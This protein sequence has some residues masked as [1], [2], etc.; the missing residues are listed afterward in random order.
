MATRPCRRSIPRACWPAPPSTARSKAATRRRRNLPGPRASRPAHGHAHL[1]R[2]S[3]SGP[4]GPRSRKTLAPDLARNLDTARELGPLL[5][6]GQQVAF[7]GAGEAALR[8]QA[9]LLQ[10]RELRGLVDA[11]LELV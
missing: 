1:V 2:K 6:L 3:M 8:R 9:E 11:A 5:L 7:L 10:G 4:G